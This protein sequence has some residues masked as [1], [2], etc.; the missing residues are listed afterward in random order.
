M[1]LTTILSALIILM[2]LATHGQQVK[3]L[4]KSDL[5]PISQV[6]VANKNKTK[7]AITNIDGE[8]DLKS[9]MAGDSLYFTHVAFQTFMVLKSAIPASGQIYLTENVIKLDEFVITGNRSEEK[10]S[11]LP[12]KIEVIQ[13]KEIA[14]Q[15]LRE[16]RLI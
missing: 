8:A 10:R 4:D 5:Q 6:S 2:T 1:K 9:F 14:F 15:N 12:N 7:M 16:S 13:A 11:D 3:V